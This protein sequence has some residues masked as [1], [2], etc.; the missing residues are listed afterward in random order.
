MKR[1]RG[2]EGRGAA[3]VVLPPEPS[4]SCTGWGTWYEYEEPG[5][6]KDSESCD[7]CSVM[8]WNRKRFLSALW[9]WTWTHLLSLSGLRWT[10]WSRAVCIGSSAGSA[11]QVF[12]R[13]RS[14]CSWMCRHTHS[15]YM[16]ASATPS[17]TNSLLVN[18][19]GLDTRQPSVCPPSTAEPSALSINSPNVASG[20]WTVRWGSIHATIE[21]SLEEGEQGKKCLSNVNL[22][23][24]I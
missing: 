15:T 2:H 7:W 10:G 1:P 22:A 24:S 9:Q 12:Q 17:V 16:L 21:G 8:G 4:G 11:S 18:Y 20:H 14:A 13:R 23:L 19:T 6:G 5:K 3:G